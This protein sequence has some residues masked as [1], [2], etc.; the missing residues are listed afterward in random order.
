M[1]QFKSLLILIGG[2]CVPGLAHFYYGQRIKALL[3]FGI[4]LVCTVLGIIIADF[5]FVR[6]SDNPFYYIGQFGS[7]LIFLLNSVFTSVTPRGFLPLPYYEIGLLYTCVAGI[8]NLVILL[9]LHTQLT[10]KSRPG[11]TEDKQPS[12]E[13]PGLT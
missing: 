3:F 13:Y 2:W 1:N 7:G 11:G 9:T 6:Y 12:R 4:I 5:R 10:K 8:L